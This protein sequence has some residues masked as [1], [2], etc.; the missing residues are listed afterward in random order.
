MK[1]S[2]ALNYINFRAT[3]PESTPGFGAKLNE[4]FLDGLH[5]SRNFATGA[6]VAGTMV[7]AFTAPEANANIIEDSFKIWRQGDVDNKVEAGAGAVN[8]LY[9]RVGKEIDAAKERRKQR[10][11]EEVYEINKVHNQVT[12]EERRIEAAKRQREHEAKLEQEGI[13][14][15]KNGEVIFTK[16]D[17]KP[18]SSGNNVE[19]VESSQPFIPAPQNTSSIAS[20]SMSDNGFDDGRV[21]IEPKVQER[22]LDDEALGRI[23]VAAPVL[24]DQDYQVIQKGNTA[25]II[26]LDD[27]LRPVSMMRDNRLPFE[28][29]LDQLQVIAAT[30]SEAKTD[31][32]GHTM[33]TRALLNEQFDAS[34]A[35]YLSGANLD[36]DNSDLNMDL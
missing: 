4:M 12:I 29:Q 2:P 26:M 10:T 13:V 34:N 17:V 8:I 31:F 27:S 30:P 1:D 16:G 36:H 6:I 9:G 33:N 15:K 28:R 23:K 22:V 5:R 7:T 35:A 18:A 11:Q 32:H 24:S 21:R 20:V 19:P 3:T 14:I 25:V